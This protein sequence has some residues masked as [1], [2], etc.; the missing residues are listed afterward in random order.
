MGRHVLDLSGKRFGKLR[1]VAQ[2]G[3]DKHG[4][5]LWLCRCTCGGTNSFTCFRL[6][7]QKVAHCGCEYKSPEK[8]ARVAPA[9]PPLGFLDK[10]LYRHRAAP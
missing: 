10:F 6:R 7:T 5:V 2:N 9:S 3:H 4:H 1:V 8:S